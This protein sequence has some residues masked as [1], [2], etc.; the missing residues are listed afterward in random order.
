MLMDKTVCESPDTPVIQVDPATLVIVVFCTF[1]L[2]AML[3]SYDSAMTRPSPTPAP[4]QLDKSPDAGVPRAG[5]TKVGLVANTAT[6]LPVSSD[7]A[8]LNQIDG[9][10]KQTTLSDSDASFPTSGAVV[11]YVASMLGPVGG[12]EVIANEVSFP[13]TA[14]AEGVVISISDAGGVVVD[15]KF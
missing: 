2:S 11:D 10:T 3:F 14:V 9:L 7:I 13:N 8:V 1:N 15:I 4:V 5:V 6:P 12:L